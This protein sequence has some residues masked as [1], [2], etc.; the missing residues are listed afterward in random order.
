MKTTIGVIR[1]YRVRQDN[2]MDR[3]FIEEL[4]AKAVIPSPWQ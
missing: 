1:G 3:E 2:A 4:F